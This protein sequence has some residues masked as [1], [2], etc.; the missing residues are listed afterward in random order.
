MR[1]MRSA[2]TEKKLNASVLMVHGGLLLDLQILRA[3]TSA[4]AV[5]SEVRVLQIVVAPNLLMTTDDTER[6]RNTEGR[7]SITR[8]K[9]ASTRNMRNTIDIS[10]PNIA[11]IRIGTKIVHLQL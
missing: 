7:R 6:R 3:T 1:T 10:H 5:E 8:K 11:G 4:V 2:E 9:S